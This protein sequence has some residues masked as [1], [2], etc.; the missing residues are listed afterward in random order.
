MVERGSRDETSFGVAD[1]S[2]DIPANQRVSQ[3]GSTVS[4]SR[5]ETVLETAA[6]GIVVTNDRG[7]I[8]MFNEACENMFGYKSHEVLGRNVTML[9][10]PKHARTH[11]QIVRDYSPLRRAEVVGTPQEVMVKAKDGS[12]FLVELTIGEANTPAGRQFVGILRDLTQ[13]ESIRSRMDELQQQLLRL[14]RRN[15]VEEMGAAIAHELNQ[16]LTA[17]T[18]YLQAVERKSRKIENFDEDMAIILEKAL[19][20]TERAGHIIQHMRRF[21]KRAAQQNR[22]TDI[23]QLILDAVELTTVGYRANAVQVH[24]NIA[25]D[26]PELKIDPVQV[27]Q[28][29]VNLLRNAIE[30]VEGL[31]NPKVYISA[32]R[33]A[34]FVSISVKDSGKGIPPDFHD[35]LF[36]TFASSKESGMGLG[37]AISNT[38]AQSHGGHFVVD[39]GGNG[40]GATFTLKLPCGPMPIGTQGS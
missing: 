4:Q 31:R 35:N 33:E 7:R 1:N 3:G 22:T 15:A 32:R 23:G 12:A 34:D 25:D 24:T 5:L 37:L 16:P 28:I 8:L 38:I 26:L 29:L 17:L 20:E 19:R 14:S 10:Q 21:G 2:I 40:S 36:K 18:L 27:E 39:P 30:A 13:R 6:D 11:D 9:M